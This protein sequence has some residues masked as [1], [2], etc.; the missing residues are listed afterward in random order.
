MANTMLLPT[1]T[2]KIKKV[3][4]MVLQLNAENKVHLYVSAECRT[5]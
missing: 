2:Q 1:V 4:E 5:G 3:T